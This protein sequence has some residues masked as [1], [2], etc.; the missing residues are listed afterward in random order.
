MATTAR[1]LHLARSTLRRPISNCRAATNTIS[2]TTKSTS[3]VAVRQPFSRQSQRLFQSHARRF[4]ANTENTSS[5]SSGGS[6]SSSA[7]YWALGLVTAAGAGYYAYATGYL[8]PAAAAEA[9]DKAEHAADKAK[10]KLK[11][12]SGGGGSAS[13]SGGGG[14]Q[15][16]NKD[17]QAVYN[18]VAK[19]LEERDDYEDG[20]YGP[21]LLRLAW[22]ASGT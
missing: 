18:H 21:L 17:Y 3:A 15:K 2:T 5:S 1:T 19:L 7:I 16:G 11:G 14:A 13:G 8:T 10:G 22:H 20:S 6:S 4:D 12:G 9:R